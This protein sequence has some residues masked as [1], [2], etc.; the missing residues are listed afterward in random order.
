MTVAAGH[1]EE[2]SAIH[3]RERLAR[4]LHDSASQ[5]MFSIRLHARA[6]EIMLEREP[7]GVQSQLEQLQTLTRS[8]L[9]NMRGLIAHL[10]PQENESIERTKT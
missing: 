9:D 7:D 1:V 4:E 10:R 8:A 5:T 2:L 3:E 6:A